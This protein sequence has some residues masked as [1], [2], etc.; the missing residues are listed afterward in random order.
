MSTNDHCTCKSVSS[1][2]VANDT[3]SNDSDYRIEQLRENIEQQNGTIECREG[4]T[5]EHENHAYWDPGCPQAV[6]DQVRS[7]VSIADYF[8]IS[9]T[10]ARNWVIRYE[11]YNP[12]SEGLPGIRERLETL[13][14]EDLGLS[15]LSERR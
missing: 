8:D 13:S 6:S 3:N 15:P 7:I 1:F 4:E 9:A 5:G 11:S 12:D 10:A 2:G 14:P